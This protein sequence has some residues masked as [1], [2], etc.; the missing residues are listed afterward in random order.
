MLVCAWP[1]SDLR[2]WSFILDWS[3]SIFGTEAW[4]FSVGSTP[5]F[6]AINF[7]WLWWSAP[8]IWIA[9]FFFSVDRFFN[10]TYISRRDCVGENR[11][12][13]TSPSCTCIF[14]SCSACTSI[15][16]NFVLMTWLTS[17]CCKFKII[18]NTWKTKKAASQLTANCCKWRNNKYQ[19]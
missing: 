3:A 4:T 9:Y 18:L 14:S 7:E 2:F 11:T 10:L 5:A 13:I 16:V 15:A 12:M 19:K 6:V 17:T 1:K 8:E